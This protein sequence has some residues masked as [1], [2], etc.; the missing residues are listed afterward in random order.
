MRSTL[1][2]QGGWSTRVGQRLPDGW[3]LAALVLAVLVSLPVLV[4]GASLL[5]PERAIWAHLAATVLAG[6][7]G[8]TSLL[9]LGVACGV[10]LIG[11]GTAWLVAACDFRGRALLESALLLPLAMPAYII[12]YTY[13]DLLQY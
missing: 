1:D 13:T 3:S 12:A 4:V 10:M 7:V 5:V 6:Y 9:V 11:I 8:H 2:L